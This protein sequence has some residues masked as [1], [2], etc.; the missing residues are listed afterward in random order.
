MRYLLLLPLI[1]AACAAPGPRDTEQQALAR[2]LAGRAAGAPQSCISGGPAQNLRVVDAHTIVMATAGTI[3]VNRIAS[4]CPG[5]QP[6]D[7]L[8]IE[9]HGSQYCRGDTFRTVSF[10]GGAVAGPICVLGDFTP[11]SRPR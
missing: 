8:I 11:F 2:E 6:L 7:T 4:G 9:T 10:G 3:W 1:L 5:L